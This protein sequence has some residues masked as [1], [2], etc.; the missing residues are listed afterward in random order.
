[1]IVRRIAH[2]T[3]KCPHCTTTFHDDPRLH[4]IGE[5]SAGNWLI[6]KLV[7]PHDECGKMILFLLEIDPPSSMPRLHYDYGSLNIR[8][9]KMIYPKGTSRPPVPTAVTAEFADDYTEAC[10]V[11]A[12][13]PKA[14]A[15]LSRRCLQH[16]LREKA[17][18]QHGNL[19]QEIQE[20]IDSGALPSYLSESIDAV[21]KIGNVAA[22]PMKSTVSGE[23]VDVE[24]D[25][26]EWTLNI[27]EALFDFYFV[28]PET[29]K[30]K[31]AALNAKLK[32]AGK[33]QMK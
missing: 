18:V 1:M 22:H 30:L 8:R 33:P 6:E 28:Q 26:A 3:M 14:S 23:I 11:L 5:D 2:F 29:L 10:L 31:K 16:I 7:C 25:E 17:G 32:D 27:L 15:A 24:D 4:S 20:V 13:S 21:R 19:Y 9:R 12:D